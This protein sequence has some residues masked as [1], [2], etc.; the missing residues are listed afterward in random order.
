MAYV[1]V[2]QSS[3]EVVPVSQTMKFIVFFRYMGVTR[4]LDLRA[5]K[6]R[7]LIFK[8]GVSLGGNYGSI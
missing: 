4:F 2:H 6:G 1:V 7:R 5:K 3:K 8:G